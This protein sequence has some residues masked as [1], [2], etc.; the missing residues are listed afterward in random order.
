[1]EEIIKNPFISYM[2]G[3]VV[4]LAQLFLRTKMGEIEKQHTDM[5]KKIDK[6][7][8]K[9]DNIPAI[10]KDLENLRDECKRRHRK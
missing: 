4:F 2:V 10:E 3:A 5:G 9:T 8:E 6:L 7:F 1:M